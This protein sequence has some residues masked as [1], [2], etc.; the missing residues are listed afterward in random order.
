MQNVNRR[1]RLDQPALY[2]VEV[3]GKLGERCASWFD[4]MTIAVESSDDGSSVTTLTGVVGDQAALHGLL[5]RVRD[6]GLLLLSVRRV[7]DQES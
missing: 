1:F 5:G 2:R 6:L 7:E 3:E 4:D